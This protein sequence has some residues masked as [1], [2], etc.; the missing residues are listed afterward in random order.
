MPG[1]GEKPRILNSALLNHAEVLVH[2]GSRSYGLVTL[3]TG[4][5]CQ[6]WRMKRLGIAL[7]FAGL[8][9]VP[10]CLIIV[11]LLGTRDQ[12]QLELPADDN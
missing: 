3:H 8:G 11:A 2:D 12:R 10:V 7:I 6:G 4:I 9:V 5:D 1:H